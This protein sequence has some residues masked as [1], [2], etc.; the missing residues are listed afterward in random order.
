VLLIAAVALLGGVLAG[1]D[2]VTRAELLEWA[3][4]SRT[5]SEA[6]AAPMSMAMARAVTP[7]PTKP[8]PAPFPWPGLSD[9]ALARQQIQSTPSAG[10]PANPTLPDH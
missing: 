8:E 5:K 2:G 4:G 1:M 6:S 3:G 9:V 10:G 7:L